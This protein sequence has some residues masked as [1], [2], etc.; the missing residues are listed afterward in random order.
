MAIGRLYYF[1]LSILALGF[2]CITNYH[3]WPEKGY[4]PHQNVGN[5]FRKDPREQE[6]Q[7]AWESKKKAERRK[8]KKENK[9]K[10]DIAKGRREPDSGYEELPEWLS[11]SSERYRER[12]EHDQSVPLSTHKPGTR[13]GRPRN[14]SFDAQQQRPN[15][16]TQQD[17]TPPDDYPPYEFMYGNG[18][19][20]PDGPIRGLGVRATPAVRRHEER[21]RSAEY[22]RNGNGQP[23]HSPPTAV[24]SKHA[25]VQSDSISP[26]VRRGIISPGDRAFSTDM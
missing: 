14:V 6:I 23:V 18:A 13:N 21:L 11:D 4:L 22:Q 15:L 17:G 10:R 5:K 7:E 19:V 3:M 1:T 2:C 24:R 20:R 8:Q 25:T 12:Y 9:K 16:S 26:P